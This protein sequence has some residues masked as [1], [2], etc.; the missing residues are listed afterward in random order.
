MLWE[1]GGWWQRDQ[2]FQ[3]VL[4]HRQRLAT[5]VW[6]NGVMCAAVLEL[7]VVPGCAV[8]LAQALPRREE[9]G[10]CQSSVGTVAVVKIPGDTGHRVCHTFFLLVL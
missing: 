1:A 5:A 4:C 10:Q 2:A 6:L 9:A 7:A 3:A 8:V